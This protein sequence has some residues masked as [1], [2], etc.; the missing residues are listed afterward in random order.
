[1]PRRRIERLTG[2]EATRDI[3]RDRSS[4]ERYRKG[5]E[6]RVYRVIPDDSSTLHS[7][8]RDLLERETAFRLAGL[9]APELRAELPAEPRTD[10][11]RSETIRPRGDDAFRGVDLRRPEPPDCF[12]PTVSLLTGARALLEA[13]LRGTDLPL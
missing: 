12:P 10:C 5:N 3:E 8:F 2:K 13:S 9:R 4:E 1:M 7:Y 11:P 6:H